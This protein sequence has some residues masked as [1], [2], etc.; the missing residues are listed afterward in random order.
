M[1]GPQLR[2]LLPLQMLIIDSGSGVTLSSQEAA[3]P[4]ALTPGM[5]GG[6]VDGVVAE[7]GCVLWFARWPDGAEIAVA[8]PVGRAPDFAELR[9]TL[10]RARS[11]RLEVMPAVNRLPA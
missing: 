3:S 2:V 7:R 11:T 4:E 5:N 6:A 9:V 8:V 10:E 1:T